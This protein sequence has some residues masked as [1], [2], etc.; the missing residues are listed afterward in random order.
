MILEATAGPSPT[1]RRGIHDTK[2]SDRE[3]RTRGG[4]SGELR[5]GDPSV[6]SCAGFGNINTSELVKLMLL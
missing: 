3:N 4:F 1:V 5:D 6:E 2:E